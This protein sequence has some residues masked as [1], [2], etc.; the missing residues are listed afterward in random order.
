MSNNILGQDDIDS[1]LGGGGVNADA[2]GPAD[3]P[4]PVHEPRNVS[5]ETVN[6]LIPSSRL[7]FAGDKPS[8]G[9][10]GTQGNGGA[11]SIVVDGQAVLLESGGVTVARGKIVV[12]NGR[13]FFQITKRENDR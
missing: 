7:V 11:R 6:R 5:S 12:K 8:P 9:T 10:A 13:H 3:P 4:E 1:L 2:V